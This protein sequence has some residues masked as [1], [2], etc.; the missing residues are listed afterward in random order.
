MSQNNLILGLLLLAAV[1]IMYFIYAKREGFSA[2][3]GG[4]SNLLLADEEGNLAT[5]Q[6]PKGMVMLWFGTETNVPAGWAL[7]NGENSTPDLRGRFVMGVNPNTNATGAE[8]IS[9]REFGTIGGKSSHDVTLAVEN[10]PAHT[11]I[12]KTG[13]FWAAC[14]SVFQ[15]DVTNDD[16]NIANDSSLTGSGTPFRVNT[17]PPYYVL[18]YI[19]KVI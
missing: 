7:C 15:S 13:N 10:L 5:I 17:M 1:V 11:H 19:I 4:S 12:Y 9:V 3:A 6:F 18:A 8:G 2:A 16:R 14:R